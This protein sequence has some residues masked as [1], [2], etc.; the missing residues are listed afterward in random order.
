MFRSVY[1][2]FNLCTGEK[3]HK[4]ADNHVFV[5]S[6]GAKYLNNWNSEVKDSSLNMEAP[7]HTMILDQLDSSTSS[8]TQLGNENNKKATKFQKAVCFILLKLTLQRLDIFIQ[9]TYLF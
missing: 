4:S 1:I 6:Q 9:H 3:L 5:F 2:F 8:L 7:S